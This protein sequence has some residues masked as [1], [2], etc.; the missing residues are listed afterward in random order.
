MHRK[1]QPLDNRVDN[2]R[3]NDR[4]P[5]I[6][7]LFYTMIPVAGQIYY[8]KHTELPKPV[9]IAL[10]SAW[11]LCMYAPLALQIYEWLSK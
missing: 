11:H 4:R 2:S 6:E 1:S 9:A 7:G 5:G 8:S 3:K 10:V